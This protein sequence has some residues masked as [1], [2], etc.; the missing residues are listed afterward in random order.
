MA[1][2]TETWVCP[3]CGV[4]VD[5]APLGLFAEVQ[6]PR[7]FHTEHVHVQ[8]GNF[9]LERVLGVGGM[10]VVYRAMD[11][12]LNRPLALK[13]LNDTFRDQPE[14]IERFENESAMMARVRHENVTAVY[15]AGRAYG[16][17][18]IAMELVEGTNLEH[19]VSKDEPMSASD[20]LY[21]IHQVA[22]GLDAAQKAGLL[23][24]DMKP[25]NIL[26][27]PEGKAKV[28]DF[29]L[30]VDS[31]EGDTE[32]I[33]WA[34]PYYVP[35]ETLE[36]KPED[37]RTD[38]YALGMTLRYLLTGIETFEEEAGSLPELVQCK[39]KLQ[40]F[41]KEYPDMPPELC[42][43]VDHMTK[44]AAA[45]RPKDYQE[46]IE[47]IADVQRAVEQYEG[48]S[49]SDLRRRKSRK[50]TMAIA[51]SV[52]AGLAL[53]WYL[54]PEEKAAPVSGVLPPENVPELTRP[55]EALRTVG[56]LLR[57]EQYEQAVGKL[58]AL[59]EKVTEPTYGAWCAHLAR[60]V[61]A[62]RWDSKAEADRAHSLFLKHIGN[63]ANA[64]A[65]GKHFM[66]GLV[67][68]DRRKY[69]T[70]ED[71]N[72]STGEWNTLKYDV[73]F[74]TG[75]LDR[76]APPLRALEL[77]ILG[78]QSSWLGAMGANKNFL[79]KIKKLEPELGEYQWLLQMLEKPS[80]SAHA[81]SFQVASISASPAGRSLQQ[82]YGLMAKH[83]L[84][85]AKKIFDEIANDENLK[86]VPRLPE[87]IKVFSEVC[88]VGQEMISMLQRRFP[89]KYK[90]GMS[91]KEMAD[92]VRQSMPVVNISSD[93]H[94]RDYAPQL[95]LDGKMETRWC[96]PNDRPGHYLTLS[97]NEPTPM[98]HVEIFWEKD[99]AQD[100]DIEIT[101]TQGVTR[102]T[103]RK[104]TASTTINMG[105]MPLRSL[106]L[107]FN[108]T[109]SWL[110]GSVREITLNT[111][112]KYL[113]Q[114]LLIIGLLLQ[115]KY[116]EAWAECEKLL[117]QNRSQAYFDVFALDWM[118]RWQG[119]HKPSRQEK[120]EAEIALFNSLREKKPI[121]WNKALTS[122]LVDPEA[123]SADGRENL[124]CSAVWNG[125]YEGVEALLKAG[126]DVN[127]KSPSSATPLHAAASLNEAKMIQLLLKAGADPMAQTDHGATPLHNAIWGRKEEAALALIPCYKSV[128]FCPD[129]RE[130]GYPAGQ[131]IWRWGNTKVLKAFL[132]AGMD[133]NDIRFT[134]KEPLLV[135]AVRFN[136]PEMIRLLLE[137]GVDKEI[138]DPHG[139]RAIDYAPDG[140]ELKKI[141][142]EWKSSE[143]SASD[144]LS[145]VMKTYRERPTDPGRIISLCNA[146]VSVQVNPGKEVKC[147]NAP[148]LRNES[149]TI[150]PQ[151]V[152][153]I[154]ERAGLVTIITANK[155][156]AILGIRRE[157]YNTFSLQP[158]TIQP[159]PLEHAQHFESVGAG[160]ILHS[161]K[162]LAGL[163]DK[164]RK[165][166]F[167]VLLRREYDY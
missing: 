36:R 55:Q 159:C 122:G 50:V 62:S 60:V 11:V 165:D 118:N 41:G 141:L 84:A 64:G 155:I 15:S 125:S 28:I 29:G 61:L 110:W 96:A 166:P 94:D 147:K 140:S 89:G 14:R 92:I 114:E 134:K 156:V 67:L 43:L 30:A 6:C 20:A 3:R 119:G 57:D 78:E 154:L 123:L 93:G 51:A 26:I 138:R 63:A 76:M 91:G 129:G 167:P 107:T 132:D 71:W 32:E 149:Q 148:P 5:I 70:V 46:L 151:E 90:P 37:V 33:I 160:K 126:A 124:L 40:P 25:G 87:R 68:A 9:R 142:E 137:Y 73:L 10:S 13:V 162:D 17:F 161:E 48:V 163:T 23:H 66:E 133:P 72:G 158:G 100:V 75:K 153:Q 21:V 117:A 39:R 53:A 102:R 34:T 127:R 83:E 97:F 106:K 116:E 2:G 22:L 146:C 101:T 27:T 80:Q 82:A 120:R 152:A 99:G 143:G 38:I 112:D 135:L 113:R 108:Q 12:V 35:P 105:N 47:E 77:F 95:A 4:R 69:P 144:K 139:K 58:L 59:S 103:F 19:M 115:T 42:D 164:M 145:E 52:L 88:T 136:R 16:Q 49:I 104:A 56:N 128:G 18:Y 109:Q 157:R 150:C 7:C 81:R 65:A 31:Q 74:Q 24:R 130:N 54:K 8:L 79:E 98:S 131:C 45:D 111:R 1:K 121:D 85:A 44:F 86:K